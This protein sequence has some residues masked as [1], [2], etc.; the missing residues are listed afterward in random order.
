M[1]GDGPLAVFSG[2]RYAEAAFTLNDFMKVVPCLYVPS[3]RRGL[4]HVHGRRVERYP[5]IS[6]LPRGTV[7]ADAVI[8]LE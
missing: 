8:C 7:F 6:L 4:W 1:A 5:A 3:R 2:I